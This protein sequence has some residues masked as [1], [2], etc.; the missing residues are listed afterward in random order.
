MITIRKMT[1][2]DVP[3]LYEIALRAFQPDVEKYG[4]YP[5]L[6]RQEKKKFMPPL[7]FGKSILADDRIVG[8]AFVVGIEKKGEVGAI[9]ID[10]AQQQKGYGRHV[11]LALEQMYPKVKKWRLDTPSENHHL[12]RFYESLGYV[13]TGEMKDPQSGMTGFIYEKEM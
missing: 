6:L 11:M 8:G 13:K 4:V 3:V 9:F 5:P 12:H 2:D 1:K 10:P 7:L